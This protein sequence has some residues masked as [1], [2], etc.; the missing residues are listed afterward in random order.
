[1]KTPLDFFLEYGQRVAAS[2]TPSSFNQTR[3]SADLP[4][5]VLQANRL[6][7]LFPVLSQSRLAAAKMQIAD[8]TA[9]LAQ[10]EQWACEH[11]GC[12]WG[13]A[14]GAASGVFILQVDAGR[15][16]NGNAAT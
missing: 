9:D 11:P 8:A 14:T 16:G 12:D 1:M 15:A 10:L 7:R 6:W 13:V 2:P 4:I 5:E 3:R